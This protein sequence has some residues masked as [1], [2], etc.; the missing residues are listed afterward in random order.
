[1]TTY[2]GKWRSS[3]RPR[4]VGS[5]EYCAPE[6]IRGQATF[7]SDIYSLGVTC[8]YLLTNVDPCG[9]FWLVSK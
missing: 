7:I 3:D 1:M 2:N 6:Q 9:F 5:M 4:N 8:M